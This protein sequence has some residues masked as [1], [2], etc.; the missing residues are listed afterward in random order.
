MHSRQL[1]N[2]THTLMNECTKEMVKY[3]E[4]CNDMG[5]L[6]KEKSQMNQDLTLGLAIQ[7]IT[8][9]E[10]VTILGNIKIVQ[11]L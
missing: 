7:G 8:E 9:K 6:E 3:K 11:D 2:N 5:N 1:I 10:S 4:F